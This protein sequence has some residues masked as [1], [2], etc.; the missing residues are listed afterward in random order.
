MSIRNLDRMFQPASVALFGA[1]PREHTVGG[2]V[3]RNLIDAGFAGQLMLVNPRHASIKDMKVYPDVA[4]LP[5]TPDL[6]VIATPPPTVPGLIAALGARGTRA[7]VVITAG[8][9][10][11][12]E[13][14]RS[15]QHEMLAAA[16]PYLLRIVGP[17]GV[18]ILVPGSHLN[19][20]FSHIAPSPGDLAFVSQ[21]GAM[22]TAVLDWAAA[23]KIGFSHVVS[24]GDTADVDFGDML[25]YLATDATTRAI[26]LYIE[27]VASARKFMS[28]ARAAARLKPVLV[29][30]AGRFVEGARAAASHTGALAGSDAV[31]EAAFRRAGV[32]RVGSMT[33]LF[34]AVET[35]AVTRS[36]NGERLA[37]LTN[38][39][40]PGVLATD[41][42]VAV[43]GR[44]GQLS[45]PTIDALD[46]LLPPT[47][48]RNNPIDIIGDADGKR[49]AAAFAA[50]IEEPN[51]DAVLVLNCPT[52]LVDSAEC[53]SAIVASTHEAQAA[54]KLD[55]RNIFTAWLGEAT[56]SEAR[57]RFVAARIPTYATPED[58]IAGFMHAVRFRRNQELMLE[59]PLAQPDDFE[60]DANAVAAI[61]AS[62]VQRGAG[63]LEAEELVAL[64]SAYGIPFAETRVAAD[65]ASAGAAA[66]AITGPVALKIRS[67][68]LTHKTE[69]GGVALNLRT[70]ARVEAEAQAMLTRI[71]AAYP[72]AKLNGFL[73]QQMIDRPG[74][75]ELIVGISEDPVFG[76]VILFGHGGIAVEQL[77]DTTLELPPL[78]E[79]LAIAQMSRTR[80]WQ[81]L[82]AY[83]GRASADIRGV[84]RVLMRLSQLAANHPEIIELDINPLLAD[85]DGVVAVDARI[86]VAAARGPAAAR[87][88]IL[89]YPKEF[90]TEV[91]LPS[92]TSMQ[93]RPIR[94]EDERAL[95][96]MVARM[97]PEDRRMRFFAA[98]KE[99]SHSLAARL[100]QIDYAREMALVA[101]LEK[102]TD[103]LGV[104]HFSAD[105]DNEHAEFAIAVRTDWK[106]RG[107][108][109]AVM[110]QLIAVAKQRGIR[111]IDGSV[112]RENSEMLRFCRDL[113]FTIT[114]LSGNQDVVGV[115]LELRSAQ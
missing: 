50:L 36:Q 19:A 48:S 93:I 88:S 66:A 67:P 94:P 35:L 99:L 53:A 60:P 16:C 8:F 3:L 75:I 4:S 84:A 44:L 49:Y 81:L 85:R 97:D 83:R 65:P 7:A 22:I 114:E 57:R 91:R 73:V 74:A 42:L 92:G 20:S 47:W 96:D 63:W 1:S 34:D 6:A 21:S 54:G 41:A 24:L 82:Q 5:A 112:M 23:R 28:A 62:A 70:V 100:T 104:A 32:L 76:P 46:R 108:G 29:V 56:A 68:D 27:G 78:N 30:K 13:R 33:E 110:Q 10:E 101:Q 45:Q 39:G 9:A 52:A 51:I 72:E 14:G 111:I 2:V 80:V 69:V 77:R 95:K 61:V 11:L 17:N 55:G 98:T 31:Y 71:G 37:I 79:S 25:E 90:V 58:A 102:S 106:G 43:G 26:L 15:L 12:G 107:V 86:R 103:I 105:P 38:G 115:S 64:L 109:F 89:P 59:T 87:L 18:G 113:G 40:G